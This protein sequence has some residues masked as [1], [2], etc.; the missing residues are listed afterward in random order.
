[1]GLFRLHDGQEK[2]LVC[3][4]PESGG[5]TSYTRFLGL[6]SNGLDSKA[7]RDGRMDT[8]DKGC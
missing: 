6:Y 7:S 8:E 4:L 3:S 2:L 5:F 1:M